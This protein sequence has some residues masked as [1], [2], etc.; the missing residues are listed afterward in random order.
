MATPH[1]NALSYSITQEMLL[2]CDNQCQDK[3]AKLTHIQGGH[4]IFEGELWYAVRSDLQFRYK[5]EIYIPLHDSY[6]R[7]GHRHQYLF[8]TDYPQG[9]HFTHL[10]ERDPRRQSMISREMTEAILSRP[11]MRPG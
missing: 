2:S 5:Y 8:R 1:F 9:V 3:A 11:P 10:G 7:D 6:W 4:A